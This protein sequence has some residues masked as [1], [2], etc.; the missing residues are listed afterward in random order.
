MPPSGGHLGSQPEGHKV[1]NVV[2]K[3]LDP[4]NINSVPIIDKKLQQ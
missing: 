4:S 3:R 1:V 2:E